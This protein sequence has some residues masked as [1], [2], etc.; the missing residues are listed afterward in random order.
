MNVF[1]NINRKSAGKKSGKEVIDFSLQ[2]DYMSSPA[3]YNGDNLYYLAS[4]VEKS[5]AGSS[6]SFCAF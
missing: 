4:E 1:T 6:K 5:F 2:S 3:E